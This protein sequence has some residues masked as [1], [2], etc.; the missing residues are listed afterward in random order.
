MLLAATIVAP[1]V[2]AAQDYIFPAPAPVAIPVMPGEVF[3]PPAVGGERVAEAPPLETPTSLE[4]A[5]AQNPVVPAAAEAQAVPY[6]VP[7]EQPSVGRRRVIVGLPT[8]VAKD[9]AVVIAPRISVVDEPGLPRGYDQAIFQTGGYTPAV[10]SPVFT[11]QADPLSTVP[12]PEPLGAEMLPPAPMP[13]GMT[14]PNAYLPE[15]SMTGEAAA[16]VFGQV[17]AD[18]RAA[19]RRG[20]RNWL[21]ARNIEGGIGRERLA[22]APFALDTSQ[23]FGN[24][25]F[26]MNSFDNT[27]FPDRAEYL[28]A[29]TAGGRGPALAERNLD[30]QEFNTQLELGSKKFSTATEFPIR[31]TN[32]DVNRNHAGFGDMKL[33][34]KT[35]FIDG[36]VWQVTQIFRS[37]FPTG[38]PSMGLGTG[39][40]SLEPGGL[41]RYK[42]NDVT[43]LHGELKYFFPVPGTAWAGQV[44]TYGLGASH[45]IVDH[46]STAWIGTFE[47]QG[48]YIGNGQRTNPNGTVSNAEGDHIIELTSGLRYVRDYGG[49]LG[50]FEWG[51]S[52]GTPITSSRFYDC[53]LKIDFR[54]SY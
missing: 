24:L 26:R 43:Y 38:S 40:V 12:L 11:A 37:Y 5:P 41:L 31:W 9:S 27:P 33:T 3:A 13:P 21:I 25:R 47:G 16:P 35:V 17:I 8:A 51:A 50:L 2:C 32:P 22:M 14:A 1:Q 10:A 28:W 39:H 36:D 49:N 54:W 19:P 34:V 7:V 20:L 46:D 44:L 42:W 15:S 48:F 45:V 29:Q 23:P 53:L 6:Q 4:A 30:Y 52:L 18:S